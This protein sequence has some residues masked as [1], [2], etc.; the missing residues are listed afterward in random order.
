MAKDNTEISGNCE[1]TAKDG[2][3]EEREENA[4]EERRKEETV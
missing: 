3:G 1:L 2:E 4:K